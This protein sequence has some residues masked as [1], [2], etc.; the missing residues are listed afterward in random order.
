MLDASGGSVCYGG[1]RDSL[2]D[3]KSGIRYE[4]ASPPREMPDPIAALLG[5]QWYP[6]F[7][8]LL[9][10]EVSIRAGGWDETYRVVD[11][12][13]FIQAV[14]YLGERFIAADTAVGCYIHHDGARI[15][16]ASWAAWA[17]EMG[18]A[19]FDGIAF[20]DSHNAWTPLRRSAVAKS[21][22]VQARRYYEVDRE[23]FRECIRRARSLCPEFRPPGA[24]YRILAQSIGYE[25]AEG[26]RRFCKRLL[27]LGR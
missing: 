6:D 5:D 21:L 16:T 27:G 9:R 19:L 25:R 8:Y 20:L 15:T 24:A 17:A 3:V 23:Q 13:K 2:V 11:D 18:R 7:C 14:A 1:W 26:F 12:R 4:K 10:R 22:F